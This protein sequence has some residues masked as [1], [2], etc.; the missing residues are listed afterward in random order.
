M[1]KMDK[2][3][4]VCKVVMRPNI[5]TQVSTRSEPQPSHVA[6][7]INPDIGLY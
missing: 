7:P 4:N 1:Y 3:Q 6:R 5:Y 2:T